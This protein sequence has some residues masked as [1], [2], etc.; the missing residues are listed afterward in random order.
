MQRLPGANV[1]RSPPA[2]AVVQVSGMAVLPQRA[3]Q[4]RQ[5]P[6]PYA[7]SEFRRV[8]QRF[9]EGAYRMAFSLASNASSWRF[10]NG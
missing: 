9:A 2:Q 8:S 10:L 1:P 5:I 4:P 7:N 6:R 3:A